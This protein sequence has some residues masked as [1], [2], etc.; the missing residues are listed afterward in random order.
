M[1]SGKQVKFCY[2]Q[3]V[4]KGCKNEV[5]TVFYNSLRQLVKAA[6]T[7]HGVCQRSILFN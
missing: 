7:A 2:C 4:G 6:V 3:I 5:K 1:V